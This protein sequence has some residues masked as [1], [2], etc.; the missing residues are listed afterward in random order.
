MV[1]LASILAN[2]GKRKTFAQMLAQQSID[3][4]PTPSWGAG[5]AR[6]LQGG[7][8]GVF[9]KADEN[10][11]GSEFDKMYGAPA[12][13][14]MSQPAASPAPSA[15]AYDPKAVGAALT[16]DQPR[17]I[18]NNNPL[19]IEDGAFLK[20]QPGYAGTDGRFGK[21]DTPE[22]GT[23]AANKLLDT[24]QNKYGLN[25]VAGIVGRW[26]PASDGN[27]VTAYAQNVAKQLGV[28]PNAP[29]T[30][31]QRPA[32]IAAM[33]QHENGKPI[34]VASANPNFVPGQ[35]AAQPTPAGPQV[36]QSAPM[37]AP[38]RTAPQI[39]PDIQAR[40][41]ALYVGGEKAQAAAMLQP[42]TTPKDQFR[43]LTDPAERARFGISADDKNAY[44]VGSDNK[45]TAINP[46]PFAVNV[47]NQGESEFSK[48]AAK[49]QAKRFDDLAAEGPA[50]KQMLS[51]VATLRDLGGK[52]GT[53][54]GAQVM[55]AL[56][57]YA[58]MLNIKVDHLDEAQAYKAIVN[59]IAPSLRVKGSGAQSDREL[60]N[61]LESLPSL[62]NTP[63]GNEIISRA[64]EG[65]SGNKLKASEI[66]A[67]ALNGV[68]TRAEADKQLREM[69][70]PMKEWREANKAV[71][72]APQT[73][74]AAPQAA[75]QPATPKAPPQPGVVQDGYRFKG[76]NPADPNSWEPYS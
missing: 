3:T 26:A 47:N 40:A 18:R 35:P 13:P 4:S 14:A 34:Q 56:G 37:G 70:D 22:G 41:R 6:A 36:A 28:D 60:A 12:A 48:E 17:G 7:L 5:L 68:I 55:A 27:N 20:G 74:Q 71:Q 43:S 76:G 72:K 66:G 21:F 59:K 52:I 65:L 51:D 16:G 69:P 8:A 67:N 9:E 33:G 29:L 61:F 15:P 25:T 64:L 32:L 54:K 30:P 73:Q 46:Q 53:G 31:E 11:S 45:V 44:Q 50:A 62:G 58:E 24:Y 1:D 75:P 39:P 57:P 63:G 23:A 42:Y 19:N 38:Q 49:H 10:K 2:E